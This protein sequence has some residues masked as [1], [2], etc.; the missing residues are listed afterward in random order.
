MVTRSTRPKADQCG[1]EIG[2]EQARLSM[3]ESRLSRVPTVGL[4]RHLASGAVGPA[5]QEQIDDT[6]GPRGGDGLHLHRIVGSS[7]ET[8]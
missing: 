8:R 4:R 2:G 1:G 7:G 5:C 6:V 3:E